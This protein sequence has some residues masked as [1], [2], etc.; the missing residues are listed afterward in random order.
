M[1][2]LFVVKAARGLGIGRK[3]M[4]HLA[5]MAHDLGCKRFDWTSERDNP[6][7]V[8][9]YDSLGADRVVEKVYFRFCGGRLGKFAKSGS[10]DP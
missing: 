8:A 6:K 9:F 2:D 4:L 1:K 7:A 3:M 5:K 10:S